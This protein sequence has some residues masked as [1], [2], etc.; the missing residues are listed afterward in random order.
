MAIE[1]AL[2][3]SAVRTHTHTHT[4]AHTHTHANLNHM[5]FSTQIIQ[6][7]IV[8]STVISG[9]LFVRFP[10]VELNVLA[11]AIAFSL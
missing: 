9:V 2:H 3:R 11:K 6:C 7:S 10:T 1:S 4:R 5:S 8:V